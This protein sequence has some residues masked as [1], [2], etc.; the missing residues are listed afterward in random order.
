MFDRFRTEGRRVRQGAVRCTWIPDAHAVPPR[1][2][3]A[4]GR[5]VGPAV[6]RNRLR[7]RL[8]AA[9]ADEARRGLP[10]G[11]YLMSASPAAP[12]L[13]AGAL[14]TAVGRIADDVRQEAAG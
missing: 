10:G 6:V 1:V 8:R 4:I 12:N 9:L 13:D 5:T 11:W 3:Y 7:R 2:A 14:R